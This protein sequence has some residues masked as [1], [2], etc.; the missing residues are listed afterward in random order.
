MGEDEIFPKMACCC[1][2]GPAVPQ[3][4]SETGGGRCEGALGGGSLYVSG[5]MR[6]DSDGG[7]YFFSRCAQRG[8][9]SM[10]QRVGDVGGKAR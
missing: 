6:S 10:L 7:G 1:A 8:C 9:G 3:A 5:R 4:V 2:Q